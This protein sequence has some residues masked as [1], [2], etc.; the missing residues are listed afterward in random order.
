MWIVGIIGAGIVTALIQLAIGGFQADFVEWMRVLLLHQ[1]AV[2]H[3]LIAVLGFIINVLYPERTAARLGWPS[4]PFQVKYGF[5]QLG[6]GV[7]GVLAIWFQGNFWVG[8]LVT[9]YIYGLSGLWTHT[10][11]I[12]RARKVTRNV[13]GVELFNIILDI[14]YHLVLTWMSLQIPGIWVLS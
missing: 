12:L 7:M 10:Q 5:A 2:S 6:L 8:V 13:A 3:G 14:V 1:F 9:L 11:E 4:G